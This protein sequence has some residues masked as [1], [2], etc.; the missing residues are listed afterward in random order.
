MPLERRIGRL[1][2]PTPA[3]SLDPL[4]APPSAPRRWPRCGWLR[5]CRCSSS[6]QS[7]RLPATTHSVRRADRDIDRA[8]KRRCKAALTLPLSAAASG[9]MPSS[10][11]RTEQS[12]GLAGKIMVL[13]KQSA[14]PMPSTIR[15]SRR[16]PASSSSCSAGFTA[17]R[18]TTNSRCPNSATVPRGAWRRGLYDR[19]AGQDHLLQRGG[20]RVLGTPARARQWCSSWRLF[21]SDG[22]AMR[23]DEC[24]MAVAL[25]RESVPSRGVRGHRRAARTVSVSRSSV[26][27][28]GITRSGR[29][30]HRR[31]QRPRRRHGPAGR[32]RT[33]A[34]GSADALHVSNAVKDE[35]LGLVSHELRTP[36]TTIFGNARLLR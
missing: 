34:S 29:P 18:A 14:G 23:H 28:A 6:M 1:R 19:A 11:V 13:A 25:G 7:Q 22:T 20:G 10:F 3:H 15:R 9:R 8:F 4:P 36:V 27:D 33:R 2:G 16:P 26:P 24:P 21:W 30:A 12:A 32:P 5:P 31:G 17:S 35:F